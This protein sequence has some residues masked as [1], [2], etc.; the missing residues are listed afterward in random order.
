[1]QWRAV[2][3][4]EKFPLIYVNGVKVNQPDNEDV[5]DQIAEWS[6]IPKQ[7]TTHNVIN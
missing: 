5:F 1:M 6:G 2:K 7:N 4:Q 3:L